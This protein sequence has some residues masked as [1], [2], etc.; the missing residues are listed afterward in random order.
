[1][2]PENLAIPADEH[3]MVDLRDRRLVP[4][5]FV[6]TASTGDD[7]ATIGHIVDHPGTIPTLNL[8]TRLYD[9]ELR[10][11]YEMV[12]YAVRARPMNE[13]WANVG[14][15][16]ASDGL[17]LQDSGYLRA[18]R[19]LPSMPVTTTLVNDVRRATQE[20]PSG[21]LQTVRPPD[22]RLFNVLVEH[23]WS[24]PPLR[25]DGRG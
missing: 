1:M 19:V 12:F 25:E 2:S 20:H 15:Y 22:E 9:R 8:R 16:S 24:P 4:L 5:D 14:H 21:G 18:L 23:G 17:S 7:V 11:A 6:L 10:R 3:V 13:M